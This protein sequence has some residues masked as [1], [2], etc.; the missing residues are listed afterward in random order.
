[1]KIQH[2]YLHILFYSVV[3][4]NTQPKQ[5]HF[6]TKLYDFQAFGSKT[7]EYTL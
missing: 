6:Q 2:E 3:S 4:P 7:Y 1:M 5:L